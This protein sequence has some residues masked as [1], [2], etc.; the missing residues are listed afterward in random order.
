MNHP[1][2]RGKS[3]LIGSGTVEGDAEQYKKR[4][5]EPGMRWKRTRAEHMIPIR[6]AVMCGSFHQNWQAIYN[7]LLD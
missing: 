5:T 1:Y 2:M 4:F 3:W 6:S 7:L